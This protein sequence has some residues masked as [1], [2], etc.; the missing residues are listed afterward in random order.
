MKAKM[1][2]KQY[3][4]NMLI[5]T[6]REG[7]QNLLNW[8]ECNGFYNAPASSKYHM[9][10]PGGLAQHTINVA[11][12]AIDLAGAFFVGTRFPDPD[13]LNSVIIC[14]LLHDIGKVGQF[15]KPQYKKILRNAAEENEGLPPYATNKDLLYIPHEIRS[16]IIASKFIDLTEEEQYAILYHN[17]LYGELNGFKNKETPLQMILH[18]ADLWACKVMEEEE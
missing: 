13:L 4:H 11:F 1:D 16:V 5:G 3:M 6:G 10:K 18:F 15:G 2:A 14:A 17:G 8:L 9:S 7:M 12:A